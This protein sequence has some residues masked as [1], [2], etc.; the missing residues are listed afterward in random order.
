MTNFALAQTTTTTPPPAPPSSPAAAAVAKIQE[1]CTSENT[2]PICVDLVYESPNIV[3]LRGD[4]IVISSSEGSVINSNFW[5]AVDEIK[6]QG[7][8]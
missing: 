7:Y 1:K 3:V 2:L 5:Q 8:N 6:A 4:Y